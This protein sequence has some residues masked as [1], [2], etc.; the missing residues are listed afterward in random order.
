MLKPAGEPNV[1]LDTSVLP[2]LTGGPGTK[3]LAG[4]AGM[5]GTIGGNATQTQTL[6]G[7]TGAMPHNSAP[8][9]PP[10]HLPC[11]PSPALC[12][13]TAAGVVHEVTLSRVGNLTCPVAGELPLFR[14]LSWNAWLAW[15]SLCAACRHFGALCNRWAR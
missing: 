7:F 2:K 12:P 15:H 8:L 6:L 5:G 11:P 13:L 4:G 9:Q 14:A 3:R 10:A 1:I